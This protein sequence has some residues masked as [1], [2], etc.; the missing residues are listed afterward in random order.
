MQLRI[1]TQNIKILENI[2]SLLYSNDKEVGKWF[3]QNLP[4]EVYEELSPQYELQVFSAMQ[5]KKQLWDNKFKNIKW[6]Y[7]GSDQCEF[8]LPTVQET[9]KAINLIKEFD[10]KYVTKDIKQFVFVTPYYWNTT[11]R[12]R[13]IDNF[14]YLN[15]NASYINNKTK[16]VEIVVNDFGT[17]K[18][19]KLY[20]NLKPIMG[21]LLIKALKNPLVDTFWLW[22]NIHIAWES[23]KNKTQEEIKQKKEEI[24]QN[25]KKWYSQ[26][27]ILKNEFF[28]KF[29]ERYC[30]KR[31][32]IDYQKQSFWMFETKTDIDIY[33][34]YALV[35]VWRLCDTSAIE[36]SKKWYYATDEVCPRTCWRYDM[37]NKNL[38]T[39]GYKLFQRWNAQYKSQLE[40]ELSEETLE[41][42][43]NRLIYTPIL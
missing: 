30:I 11:I 34:P 37:F 2:E 27:S 23:M 9:E 21:R 31:A 39:V 20:E 12:Q 13:L 41:K 15:E 26:H 25:Q 42:Y 1:N 17:L 35:F 10:K 5:I 32:W 36:N 29:L 22:E 18:L 16:Q 7:F 3:A 43:Q 14:E 28:Q 24:A 40:L 4:W 19:V 38:E 33:Y 8:L 6:F